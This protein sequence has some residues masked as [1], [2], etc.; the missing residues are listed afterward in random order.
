[1]GVNIIYLLHDCEGD[2]IYNKNYSLDKSYDHSRDFHKHGMSIWGRGGG[3][4]GK[5][6]DDREI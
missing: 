1:M 4:D 6:D 3:Y 5:Y 2:S